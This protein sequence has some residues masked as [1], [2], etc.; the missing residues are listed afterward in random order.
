MHKAQTL[1]YC[2]LVGYTFYYASTLELAADDLLGAG[3]PR[4]HHSRSAR[5]S[6][7]LHVQQRYHPRRGRSVRL[8]SVD[9]LSCES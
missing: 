3:A 1:R 5:Y 6:R 9:V 4:S 8:G 7:L 2:L